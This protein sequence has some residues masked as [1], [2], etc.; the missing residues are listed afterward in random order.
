L[1]NHAV[2]GYEIKLLKSCGSLPMLP[3]GDYFMG[4]KKLQALPKP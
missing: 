1:N 2:S 4:E 3:A